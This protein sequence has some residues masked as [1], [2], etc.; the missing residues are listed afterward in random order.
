MIIKI[1]TWIYA[2]VKDA[3]QAEEA[4][5]ALMRLDRQINRGF[6]HGEIVDTNVEHYEV[7]SDDEIAE[8]GLE[9]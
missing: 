2:D 3:D 9:E 1:E 4:C 6:P 8:R 7:V 5:R